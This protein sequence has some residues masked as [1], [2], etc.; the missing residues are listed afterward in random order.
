MSAGIFH[1]DPMMGYSVDNIFPAI[2]DQLMATFSGETVELEWVCPSD[3]DFDYFNIYRQDLGS[4][5]SA[6]VFSSEENFSVIRFS[7]K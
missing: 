7:N 2:P 3:D 6:T 4:S 5:E 1:S